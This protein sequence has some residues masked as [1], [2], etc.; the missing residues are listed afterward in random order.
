MA[1]LR[2]A[3]L[4]VKD[5][6]RMTE[7]YRDALELQELP[8]LAQDGWVELAAGGARLALHV[9]PAQYAAGITIKSPPRPRESAPTKLVLDVD[10]LEAARVCLQQHG[11]VMRE[12]WDFGGCDG[13]D[14]EGQRLPDRP[15]FLNAG[16]G[17]VGTRAL[18]R[19]LF[20][21]QRNVEPAR[22]EV[23]RLGLRECHL[24]R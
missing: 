8:E 12:P 16:Q 13:T 4:F 10:D 23:V 24:A 15:A 6:E 11:A 5:L 20:A 21:Q 9:I 19:A 7:F 1:T 3:M 17:D 2:L 14:P 22:L 18:Q